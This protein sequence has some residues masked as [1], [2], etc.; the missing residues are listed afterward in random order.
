MPEKCRAPLVLCC[1]EGKTNEEAARLLGWPSGPM[2]YRLARGREPLRGH[3]QARLAGLTALLSATLLTGLISLSVHE[4]MEATPHNLMPS[5]WR[6]WIVVC[7][8]VLAALRAEAVGV[9]V[10]SGLWSSRDCGSYT[11]SH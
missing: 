10:A 7:S 6:L 4:L 9:W 3:L 2:S 1:L 8:L 5:R 11:G